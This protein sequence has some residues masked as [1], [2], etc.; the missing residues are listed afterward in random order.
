MDDLLDVEEFDDEWEV[1][2]R[3]WLFQV[4][5]GLQQLQSSLSLIHNDLHTNN[6]LWVPTQQTHF[7]YQDSK[8]NIW[9]IPTFGK[10]FTIID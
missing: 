6:I 4:M 5:V 10:R 1:R 2:W 3:A 7:R 8:G 9:L